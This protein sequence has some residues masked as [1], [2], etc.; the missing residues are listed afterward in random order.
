MIEAL[1]QTL[2][3]V[4]PACKIVDINRATHYK[5][6]NDDPKYKKQVSDIE[7]I[8]IDF[9]ESKLHTQIKNGDTTAT[10]FYLKTKGR[11]RGYSER[12]EIT[13]ADGEN[14]TQPQIIF[15]SVPLSE[16]DVEE[17]KRIQ[18][19]DGSGNRSIPEA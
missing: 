6:L 3:V 13:G 16:K 5:W 18:N 4:T 9:A 1:E 14:L 2:G 15:T 8:A 7:N 19:G 12:M 11:K 10:I 17:I